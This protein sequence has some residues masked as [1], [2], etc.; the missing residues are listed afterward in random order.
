VKFATPAG[1]LLSGLTFRHDTISVTDKWNMIAPGSWALSA[2]NVAALDSVTMATNF[3]GYFSAP[4]PGYRVVDTLEPG[5]AYWIKVHNPGRIVL[6]QAGPAASGGPAS[7]DSKPGSSASPATAILGKMN[8]LVIRDSAGQTGTLYFAA[9][10]T[11][12]DLNKWELPPALPAAEVMDVR[13][14][15]GR[16]LESADQKSAREVGIQISSA[17]YPLSISW[18]MTNPSDRAALRIGINDL[19]ISGSGSIQITQASSTLALELQGKLEMELPKQF[20]LR[21]NYPNPFNPSTTIRYDL[22][23]KS[24]VR[25]TVYN[26]L[27]QEVISLVDGIQ[28][29]GFKSVQWDGISASSGVYFY[30]ISVNGIDDA[31]QFVG[32]GKMI[33]VK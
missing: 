8:Q 29:A 28:E 13:F 24:N 5:K 30:R 10:P 4:S 3:Y 32:T 17:R 16:M 11:D 14:A 23:V 9:T 31:R 26:I 1:V 6:K 21:Q 27:G 33:L 15:T 2:S 7:A 12:I 22:P 18:Q 19:P 25:L 20:A